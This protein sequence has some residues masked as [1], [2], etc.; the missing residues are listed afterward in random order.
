[1]V[2]NTVNL[3]LLTELLEQLVYYIEAL[4]FLTIRMYFSE[5]PIRKISILYVLSRI[6]KT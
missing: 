4:I 2:F 1:M 3:L 6:L 5:E